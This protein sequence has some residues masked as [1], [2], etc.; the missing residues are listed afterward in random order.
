MGM[1]GGGIGVGGIVI[2]LIAYFLGFD[3]GAVIDMAEQAGA[4]RD[5]R[6]G[7]PRARPPTTRGSSSPRSSAAP[8][9]SG[10]RSSSSREPSTGRRR[11]CSTKGRCARPAA[12]GR[13]R[14]GRSTARAT[15]SS[16]S[17]SRSSATCRRAS[18]RPGDFAQAYVIAHEVAHHVQKLTGSFQKL[19]AARGRVS[20]AE[21]NRLSVRMELQADCYAGVWGHHAGTMNQLDAGDI[22]EALERRHRDRRRSP[23][24]A[25]AGPRGA[26]VLHPRHLGAARALVQ[27]RPGLGQREELRHLFRRLALA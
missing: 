4:R 1:V 9:T 26:R 22:E 7:R 3:P 8:R 17:T 14:W 16:T 5:T 27:A 13:R 6:A 25:D 19:E 18:A 21:F 12:W 15:R 24:E 2:A 10:A 23:A 20:Q 11:W